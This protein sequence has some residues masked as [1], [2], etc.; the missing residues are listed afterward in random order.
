[1]TGLPTEGLLRRLRGMPALNPWGT[2]VFAK[3]SARWGM[4]WG[5]DS[6]QAAVTAARASCGSASQCSVEVSFFGASCGAFA[7]VGPGWAI[8][9]RSGIAQ[10][11]EAALADCQ[12]G[13]KACRIIA[14]VCADG[15]ERS[16]LSP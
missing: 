8:A 11:K 2:I 9:S 10:A 6:R 7:Y 16:G 13:G 14:T 15:S 1:V 12:K 5:K 4:A 3:G